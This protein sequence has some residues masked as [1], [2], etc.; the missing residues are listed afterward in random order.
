[1]SLTSH[2]CCA[3]LKIL[4]QAWIFSATHTITLSGSYINRKA[5]NKNKPS[6][7]CGFLFYHGSDGLNGWVLWWECAIRQKHKKPLALDARCLLR[8]IDAVPV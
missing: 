5:I 1:M 3:R 7:S 6:L 2:R 4:E 8:A